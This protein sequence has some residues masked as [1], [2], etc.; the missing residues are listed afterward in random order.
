MRANLSKRRNEENSVHESL[1]PRQEDQ[2]SLM[3]G[4]SANLD[5]TAIPANA[6]NIQGFNSNAR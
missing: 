6:S 2:S 3:G 5:L 1:L 4:I